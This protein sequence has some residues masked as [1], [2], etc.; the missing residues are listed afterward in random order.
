KARLKERDRLAAEV[1][2]LRQAGKLGG[3]VAAMEKVLAIERARFG[4]VHGGGGGSLGILAEIQAER[5]GYKA[6][7]KLRQEVVS[8]YAKLNGDKDWRTIDARW[9]LDG[10]ERRARLSPAD[11][12]QLA[13]AGNL[14]KQVIILYGKGRYKDALPLAQKVAEIR[15]RLLT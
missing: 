2:K 13:Q 11:R 9:E 8:I 14:N 7:R 15:K 3:A 1:T 6:A 12:K 5:E 4:Q 10:L